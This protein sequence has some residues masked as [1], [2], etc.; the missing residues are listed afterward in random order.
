[1]S[2]IAT[3][4]AILVASVLA[5]AGV[6]KLRDRSAT[7]RS[8]AQLGLRRPAALATVVPLVEL[9]V[10]VCLLLRPSV[11]GLIAFGLFVMFTALLVPIVAQKRSV[12]CGCFGS[13]ATAPVSARTIVR[14]VFFIVAALS[15]SVADRF[16]LGWPGAIAVGAAAVAVAVVLSLLDMR[17]TTGTLFGV[18]SGGSPA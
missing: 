6:A 9:A 17:A 5:F 1:M 14:N 13:T 12:A 15:A 2:Q 16:Q 4:A 3:A 18:R 8:F 10:S 11:G 7:I